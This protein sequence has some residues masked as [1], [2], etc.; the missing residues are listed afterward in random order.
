MPKPIGKVRLPAESQVPIVGDA[1]M[2]GPLADGRLIPVLILDTVNHFQL[3]ELIRVHEHVGPGDVGF[4][5][6]MKK[7]LRE[8]MLL[9]EFQRPMEIQ[10]VLVFDIEKYASLVELMLTSRAVYLQAGSPGDRLLTT[11]EDPRLLLEL[12]DIGFRPVWDAALLKRM[13]QVMRQAGLSRT[14]AKDGAI[15]FI[16]QMRELAAFRLS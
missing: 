1:A 15:T 3:S 5:W 13:T 7:G 6:G 4:Q 16:Q 10:I 14:A 8:A 12:P 9:L 11:F 2:A